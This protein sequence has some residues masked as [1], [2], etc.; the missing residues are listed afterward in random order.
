LVQYIQTAQLIGFLMHFHHLGT[1][2]IVQEKILVNLTLSTRTEMFIHVFVENLF[3]NIIERA[4]KKSHALLMLLL[5]TKG[6][7][8]LFIE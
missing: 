7:Y 2:A 5:I 4:E 3:T 6:Y 1:Y 8:R